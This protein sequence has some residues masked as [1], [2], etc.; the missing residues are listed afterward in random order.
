[1]VVSGGPA[2]DVP[3]RGYSWP[4]FQ[5]GH[6]LSLRHGARS[7]RTYQPLARELVAGVLVERPWL[8]GYPEALAAWSEAEARCDLLRRW[9]AD[10]ELLDD[11][12]V[13]E[14]V[15]GALHWLTRLETVADRL[16]QRL[17]LDAR[18]DVEL[19]KG[20]AEVAR[21]QVD[22]AAVAAAGREALGRAEVVAVERGDDDD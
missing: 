20:Q 7:P 21:T 6:T 14:Q 11:A 8:A 9:L 13:S 12:G 5:P 17:G 1:L 19:L 15:T 18:S 3:A 2:S 16:R 4:P 10:R 22:L